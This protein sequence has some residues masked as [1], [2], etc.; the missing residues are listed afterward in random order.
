MISVQ[1]HPEYTEEM[2][3]GIMGWF[4]ENSILSDDILS[5]SLR[6]VGGRDDG[7]EVAKTFLRFLS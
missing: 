5:E 7:V 6:R 4:E 2:V 3:R 1:G